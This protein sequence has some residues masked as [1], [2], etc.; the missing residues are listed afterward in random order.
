MASGI[1]RSIGKLGLAILLLAWPQVGY[2]CGRV[3]V[4]AHN[5]VK[6]FYGVP[7]N[8]TVSGLKRLPFSVKVGYRMGEAGREAIYRVKAANNVEMEI[9][10]DTGRIYMAETVSL[11]AVGPKCIGVGSLLS[12]VKAAWPMGK[13]IYGEEE[14]G[15]VTY[16]TGTNV[17]YIFDPKDMPPSA[18]ANGRKNV[19]VPN[20]RVQK[21]RILRDAN[22]VP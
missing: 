18:L 6:S 10:F 1:I 19:E 9:H 17:L 20:M 3:L 14:G 16:V 21:I 4:D 22:P 5:N 13:L 12:D 8:L 2:A 15:F 11:N 7:L